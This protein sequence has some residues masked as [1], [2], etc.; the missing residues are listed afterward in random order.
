[1]KILS[2]ADGA[3]SGLALTCLI[4]PVRRAIPEQVLLTANN[5]YHGIQEVKNP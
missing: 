4:R 5:P 3:T 1:M 2:F